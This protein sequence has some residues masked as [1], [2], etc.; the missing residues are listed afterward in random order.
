MISSWPSVQEIGDFMVLRA[1]GFPVRQL[2]CPWLHHGSLKAPFFWCSHSEDLTDLA[3]K[4]KWPGGLYGFMICFMPKFRSVCIRQFPELSEEALLI[5]GFHN[6]R[7]SIPIYLTLLAPFVLGMGWRPRL[8]FHRFPHLFGWGVAPGN[9]FARPYCVRAAVSHAIPRLPWNQPG[10]PK[11]INKLSLEDDVPGGIW[12]CWWGNHI[13]SGSGPISIGRPGTPGTSEWR[14][15]RS[16][17][18]NLWPVGHRAPSQ[19]HPS[20]PPTLRLRLCTWLAGTPRH[21]VGWQASSNLSLG[22]TRTQPLQEWVWKVC[23]PP[24][25]PM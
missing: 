19:N 22:K 15:W 1:A 24:S 3:L 25:F 10:T 8:E 14:Q 16:S 4:C 18:D 2:L 23:I 21:A 9:W 7:F 12:Q 6:V 11:D 17:F 13:P 5:C 20:F